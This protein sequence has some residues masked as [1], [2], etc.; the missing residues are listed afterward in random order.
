[1]ARKQTIIPDSMEIGTRMVKAGM[2]VRELSIAI[3]MTF[4]ETE[5][6]VQSR[7]APTYYQKDVMLRE[8][9]DYAKKNGR[10]IDA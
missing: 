8:I 10:T 4:R 6:I 9:A 2:S 5:A 3:N 7:V 1:M